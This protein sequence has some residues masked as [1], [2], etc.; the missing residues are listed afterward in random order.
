MY[1][2]ERTA[3][4]ETSPARDAERGSARR[5]LVLSIA[6]VAVAVLAIIAMVL[7]RDTQERRKII[8]EGD[9]APAFT[10]QTIDQRTVNLDEQRGKVVLV[11]FWATWCPPC[12]EEM[13]QLDSL[14]RK[15][16]GPDFDVLAVSVD[17]SMDAL[18][19]F[20]RKKGVSMPVL[21]DQ[22]RAVA[23]RYGTFKFPETYVL[24][25]QGTVRFKVIGPMDWTMPDAVRALRRLI[26]EK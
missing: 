14:Y 22:E 26:D 25:R 19:S 18:N 17:E 9:V 2:P 11:H 7:T 12:V 13:P 4:K 16:A 1:R 3:K 21:V 15:L 5:G 24:D 23:S 10:L 8:V 20:I 6:L